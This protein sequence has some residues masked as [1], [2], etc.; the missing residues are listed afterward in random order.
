MI[1]FKWKDGWKFASQQEVLTSILLDLEIDNKDRIP[2]IIM[3]NLHVLGRDKIV[4]FIQ[5]PVSFDV[6]KKRS[7]QSQ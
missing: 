2:Y 5:L 1:V 6:M 7:M 4:T 3:Q